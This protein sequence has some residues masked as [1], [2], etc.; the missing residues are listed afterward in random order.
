ME[1]LRAVNVTPGK[2]LSAANESVAPSPASIERLEVDKILTHQDHRK[3][4]HPVID[5]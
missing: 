1:A 3:L 2:Q 4:L 5:L